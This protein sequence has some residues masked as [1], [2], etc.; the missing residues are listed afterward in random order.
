MSV[1]EHNVR[2]NESISPSGDIAGVCE[3]PFGADDAV[4]AL[5]CH[6]TRTGALLAVWSGSTFLHFAVSEGHGA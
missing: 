3:F 2:L 1:R 4:V 6:N 5:R